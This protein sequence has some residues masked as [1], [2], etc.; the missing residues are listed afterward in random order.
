MRTKFNSIQINQPTRCNNFSS[1]LSWHLFTAQHVSGV[2]TPNIRSYNCSSSLWFY[3]W[4]VVVAV[5][6]V[7]V[8]PVNQPARPPEATT[9][10]TELLMMGVWTSETCWAVL[11]CQDNKVEKLLHLVGDLFELYDDAR[12]CKLKKKHDGSISGRKII[13][14]WG[15]NG[16]VYWKRK[17]TELQDFKQKWFLQQAHKLCPG[18]VRKCILER[19]SLISN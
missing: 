19:K 14:C 3:R 15:R 2:L 16:W 5:L 9:V 7:E 12:N 17:V 4:S 11:K 18:C 8:G 6:L 13:G 1:S 10:V